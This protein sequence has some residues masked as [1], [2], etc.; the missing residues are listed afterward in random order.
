MGSWRSAQRQM[1]RLTPVAEVA[2]G[3]VADDTM[4]GLHVRTVFDA[5]RDDATARTALGEAA[6]R[7]AESEYGTEGVRRL[8]Q[9][10]N[11]SHWSHFVPP[12]AAL[13]QAYIGSHVHQHVHPPPAQALAHTT[14]HGPSFAHGPSDA[15]GCALK[16]LPRSRLQGR[17][18]RTPNVRR[19][20]ESIFEHTHLGIKKCLGV[21][22]RVRVRVGLGVRAG[23]GV[24]TMHQSPQ[25]PCPLQALPRPCSFD[26]AALWQRTVRL[27]RLRRDA[28]LPHRHDESRSH[29]INTRFRYCRHTPT[30][31][32]GWPGAAPQRYY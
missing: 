14:A 16:V 31:P 13:L 7:A 17:L 11:A 6:V 26:G 9:W 8:M 3:L 24:H 22:L 32:L 4:V 30:R 2:A 29:Q 19:H 12:I 27:P 5:P 18:R 23:L 21:G 10:R 15:G 28:L 1:G 20:G 25:H